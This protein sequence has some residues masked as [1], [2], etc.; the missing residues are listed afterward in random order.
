VT[1]PRVLLTEDD[2]LQFRERYED[3]YK[4]DSAWFERMQIRRENWFDRICQCC[5][6]IGFKQIA[7]WRAGVAN[8]MPR[9]ETY[10]NLLE[11][12][13][14]GE[15]GT[16][17]KPNVVYMPGNT[18]RWGPGAFPLRLHRSH[19]FPDTNLALDLYAPRSLVRRWFQ[20]RELKLPPWL[21]PTQPSSSAQEKETTQPGSSVQK[22]PNGAADN[23]YTLPEMSPSKRQRERLATYTALL[24]I[25]PNR[26]IPKMSAEE[27][28]KTVT[29]ERRKDGSLSVTN[30]VSRD[31]VLRALRLKK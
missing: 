5:D 20:A 27:L 12:V 26:R 29:R 2:H 10:K 23:Y 16:G 15:F 24:R 25:Y 19:L 30:V 3:R 1:R 22:Q 7:D 13:W 4:E 28:A 8:G 9:E 6:L 17:K 11:A 31:S 14:N 21:E 18:A